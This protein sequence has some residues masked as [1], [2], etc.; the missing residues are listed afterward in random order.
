MASAA[1][2]NRQR[3]GFIADRQPFISPGLRLVASDDTGLRWQEL[4]FMYSRL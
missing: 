3:V 2:G 1:A 4:A